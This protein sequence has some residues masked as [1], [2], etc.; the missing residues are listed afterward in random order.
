M[1]TSLGQD[2]CAIVW[3]DFESYNPGLNSFLS[4]SD[5][6][7]TKFHPGALSGD[8]QEWNGNYLNISS[9]LSQPDL[10]VAPELLQIIDIEAPD[11]ITF[12][13]DF[14]DECGALSLDFLG[15]EKKESFANFTSFWNAQILNGDTIFP[16]FSTRN[17]F[18]HWSFEIN[19]KEQ[20]IFVLCPDGSRIT[21]GFLQPS[22]YLFG[23]AYGSNQCAFIDNICLAGRALVDMDQDGYDDNI[24]CHDENPDIHPDALEIPNNGIDE[25][26][27]GSDLRVPISHT[28]APVV[29][30]PNPVKNELK[31]LIEGID[32]GRVMIYDF[33]G[34]PILRQS[35]EGHRITLDLHMLPLGYFWVE[36]YCQKSELRWIQKLVKQ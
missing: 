12:S 33:L 6:T 17:E 21:R 1:T 30:Q 10:L 18:N 34:R 26:C 8:V 13:L 16:C 3:E 15:S 19:F 5:S 20:A 23:I 25:N 9:S 7:W 4:Q 29:M 32:N 22:Q 14:Y 36:V 31:I 28:I 27:D 11:L 2:T 24:D 35:F